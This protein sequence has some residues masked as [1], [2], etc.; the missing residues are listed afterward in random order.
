[1]TL[2]RITIAHPASRI[3]NTGNRNQDQKKKKYG[4]GYNA[5]KC[6]QCQ[7]NNA[8]FDVNVHS[9]SRQSGMFMLMA[10]VCPYACP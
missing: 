6:L 7:S 9:T 4:G 8:N 3:I 2:M 5:A 10:S 1:V